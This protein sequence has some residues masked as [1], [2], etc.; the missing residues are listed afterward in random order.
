MKIKSLYREY[1]Q[2]SRLFAYPLL[3]IKRGSS[4]TP[5]QTFMAWKGVYEFSESKLICQYHMR[6]DPE[7]MM[8]ESVKLKGN[9]L[10]HTCHQLEDGTC[11][12]VFD[13]SKLKKDFDN[14]VLGKYSMLSKESKDKI[15]SFFSNSNQHYVYI[16][17]YLEPTKYYEI[18]AQLLNVEQQH[19]K[20]CGQLCSKP[21]LDKELLKISEKTKEID[22]NLLNLP[23]ETN[24]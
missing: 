23:L 20:A 10:F 4:I 16:A 6:T 18:Y 3:N 22:N 12:Y 17:S 24:N 1:I 11:L 2:K 7:F 14:I 8:F 5:I 15:L 13:L 21:N 9:P 19:L